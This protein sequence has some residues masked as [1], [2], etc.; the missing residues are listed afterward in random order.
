MGEMDKPWFAAKTYGLGSGLPIAWQGW[1][2][3]ALFLVALLGTAVFVRWPLNILL[4]TIVVIAFC[5]VNAAKT[6]GG[7]RWRWGGED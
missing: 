2:A 1:V 3:A 4:E 5:V 6:K 7:W